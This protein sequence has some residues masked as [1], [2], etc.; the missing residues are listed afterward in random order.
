MVTFKYLEI[1]KQILIFDYF[2]RWTL[3]FQTKVWYF[4]TKSEGLHKIFPST[5]GLFQ[6]KGYFCP[7][8]L[9]ATWQSLEIITAPNLYALWTKCFI[10]YFW[11]IQMAVVPDVSK[12]YF[13]SPRIPIGIN[14]SQI[15]KATKKGWL[16]KYQSC[17]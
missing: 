2:K 10:T 9:N 16:H 7:I 5:S 8:T 14:R 15:M 17:T 13:T 12:N 11:Q 1:L 3:Y 4:N 6:N